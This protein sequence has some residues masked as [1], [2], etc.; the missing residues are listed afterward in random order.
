M[1]TFYLLS[2]ILILSGCGDEKQIKQDNSIECISR[3]IDSGVSEETDAGPFM[4]MPEIVEKEHS[5]QHY[6][7][8]T[9]N[10]NVELD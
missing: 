8:E 5:I 4:K 6:E 7:F 3:S 10:L 2:I 9:I 1:K